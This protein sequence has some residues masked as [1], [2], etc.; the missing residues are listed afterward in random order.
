MN[1]QTI[2]VALSLVGLFLLYL[3]PA[4]S[5]TRQLLASD[6]FDPWQIRM[7]LLIVWLVPILGT[8]LVAVMLLPHIPVK[9]GQIPLLEL[10]VLSAFVSSSDKLVAENNGSY[11]D[12][13]GAQNVAVE[14]L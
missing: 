2:I 8:S 9:C 12:D 14:D 1:W 10:L 7:Q 13:S 11:T 5:V 3:I 4:I 6:F